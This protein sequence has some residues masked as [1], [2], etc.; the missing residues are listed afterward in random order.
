MDKKDKAIRLFQE[1]IDLPRPYKRE[2]LMYEEIIK[3][4]KNK[5]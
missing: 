4:L 2:E 1:A 5:S 3:Q